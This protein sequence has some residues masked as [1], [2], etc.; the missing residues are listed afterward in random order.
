MLLA[1][2]ATVNG[3]AATLLFA[4]A[5]RGAKLLGGAVLGLAAVL[6]DVA[7]PWSAAYAAAGCAGDGTLLSGNIDGGRLSWPPHCSVRAVATGTRANM[8]R[9]ARQ[10]RFQC[11]RVG[12]DMLD[13]PADCTAAS[14]RRWH[15]AA[16]GLHASVVKWW[17]GSGSNFKQRLRAAYDTWQNHGYWEQ[18]GCAGLSGSAS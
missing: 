15:A 3:A 4:V 9:H 6:L 1:D 5:S 12:E 7:V 13:R 10:T 11:W 2:G 18:K 16:R 14:I 17:Y 8:T